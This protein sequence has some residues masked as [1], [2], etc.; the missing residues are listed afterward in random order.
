MFEQKMFAFHSYNKV[1]IELRSGSI[2]YKIDF[3]CLEDM[4]KI[5][6]KWPE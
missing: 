6:Y 3:D 4:H 2:V 1:Y 5:C